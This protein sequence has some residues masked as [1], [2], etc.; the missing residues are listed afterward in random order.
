L[1]FQGYPK[2]GNPITGLVRGVGNDGAPLDLP[3]QARDQ[4]PYATLS[5]ANGP[6]ARSG[7]ATEDGDTGRP[8][9]TDDEVAHPSHRQQAAIPLYSET[10]GGQDVAIYAGGPKAYLFDGTVEQNYIYYVME[11]ALKR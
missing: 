11:D 5:Y 9:L 1:A 4:R 8:F 7:P 6:G 3:E 10:H 2:R